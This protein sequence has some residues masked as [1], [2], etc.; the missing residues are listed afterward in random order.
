M[1]RRDFIAWT[2]GAVVALPTAA[3]AQQP[4][5]PMIGMLNSASPESFADS[6]AAFRQ[7]LEKGGFVE[8]RDVALEYRW[9]EGRYDRL[10]AQAAEL[11][12]RNVRVLVAVSNVSAQAAKAATA[13]VPIVFLVGS[14][15]VQGGL[16]ASFSR[17]GGNATGVNLFAAELTAKRLG[18]LLE[19]RPDAQIIVGLVNPSRP[20]L[21]LQL[22]DLTEAAQTAGRQVRI[23][24]A[25]NEREIESAFSAMVDMRAEALLIGNDPF[26]SSRRRQVV[27]LAAHHRIPAIYEWRE[28]PDA[29]GLMSYG[30]S[31][32]D[33]HRL[34]GIY[35]AQILK[36]AKPADLPVLQPTKFELVINLKTAKALSL[37]VPPTLIA[38]ADEV[39]E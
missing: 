22:R 17:P 11:I 35:T 23:L 4:V 7:S 1:H 37:S 16:V 27:A 29:G 38:R 12:G 14:N 3:R 32:A 2:G 6:L 36:G 9:A 25:S 21:A 13:T 39:I 10:P 28:A 33:A 19:L 5:L 15:P 34:A 30:S 31:L 26:F 8:A 20:N 24:N 18:L